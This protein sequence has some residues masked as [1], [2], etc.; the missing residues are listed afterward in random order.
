MPDAARTPGA[1]HSRVFPT[2]RG[3]VLTDRGLSRVFTDL[4]IDAVPH[5]FRSSF[6]DWA[7]AGGAAPGPFGAHRYDVRDLVVHYN[8]LSPAQRDHFGCGFRRRSH[9]AR[10]TAPDRAAVRTR[11]SNARADPLPY[12]PR[13]LPLVVLDRGQDRQRVGR[14]H[15]GHGH[16]PMRGNA[17]ARRL[18]GQ[19][20]PYL[21]P[22]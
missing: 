15:L 5:D 3:K 16:R 10:R 14:G 1:G 7:A 18:R 8:N 2:A 12:P 13:G 6:R 11:N 9:V 4:K 17:Y 21:A 22:H 20:C 19:A